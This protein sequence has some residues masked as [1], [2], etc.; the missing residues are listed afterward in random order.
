MG[1]GGCDLYVGSSDIG[2]A[3]GVAGVAVGFALSST[4]NSSNSR[5]AYCS[6]IRVGANRSMVLLGAR[7]KY[8]AGREVAPLWP[9]EA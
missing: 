9:N 2:S 1:I 8:A 7:D 3:I 5:Y 4:L 6:P